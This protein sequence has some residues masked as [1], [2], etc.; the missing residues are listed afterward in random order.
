MKRR[1]VNVT[2]TRSP[3]NTF[4]DHG[5]HNSDSRTVK[6]AA[7]TSYEL[8]CR[9][10]LVRHSRSQKDSDGKRLRT[11][12]LRTFSEEEA[13]STCRIAILDDV[14]DVEPTGH[15]ATPYETSRT[16]C[17]TPSVALEVFHWEPV[18]LMCFQHTHSI[19]TSP[20][21]APVL[22]ISLKHSSISRVLG[23]RCV[24]HLSR[25]LL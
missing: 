24:V 15:A 10:L 1:R 17:S 19:T 16:V 22:S 6:A 23:N 14:P 4:R 11:T 18:K 25:R 12:V 13:S 8:A 9:R 20:H 7:F 2:N 3:L 5:T 21:T